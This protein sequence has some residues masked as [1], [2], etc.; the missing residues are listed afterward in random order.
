MLVVDASVAVKWVT[1]EHDTALAKSLVGSDL[2][3]APEIVLAETANTIWKKG[4]LGLITPAQAAR[5]VDDLPG[6]FGALFQVEPLLQRAYAIAQALSHPI[7]DCFYLAL[8]EREAA[9]LVTADKRLLGRLAGTG[10]AG[11]AR[12]LASFGPMP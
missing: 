9:P 12:D 5:A 2:L 3:A 7:Y 11:N 6:F 10:W 4:R 1:R 8:A